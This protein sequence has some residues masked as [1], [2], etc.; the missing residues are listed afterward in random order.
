MVVL[1][2]KHKT[3]S[4]K[5]QAGR[6]RLLSLAIH[7][8]HGAFEMAMDNVGFLPLNQLCEDLVFVRDSFG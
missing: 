5:K 1:A 7:N 8:S 4:L 3:Y 2:F 6:A